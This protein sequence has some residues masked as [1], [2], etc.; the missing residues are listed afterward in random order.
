MNNQ[1]VFGALESIRGG[2]VASVQ[3]PDGSPLRSTA[4]ISALTAAILEGNPAGL[5]I[6][7]PEDIRAVRS[8]TRLPIIGLHKV[9]NGTRDI[10]TPELSL[11]VGLAQA[12]ADIIA[13]DAT[14]EVLG[15]DF[16]ILER[17]AS[18]TGLPVMADI[19]TFEEACRA[20]DLGVAV[21]STTLSG[22]TPESASVDS[23]P[24]LTLVSQL[25]ERGMTVIG[26]GRY[27]TLAQVESGFARGAFAIVVG[28]AISDPGSIT[29]EF[30]DVSPKRQRLLQ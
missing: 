14:W 7:G 13:V 15:G 23:G 16:S 27:R 6:N 30:V 18:E 17:V 3:A 9:H 19:S 28:G 1:A 22:Y 5:R 4:I 29:A 8:L 11:A 26:E 12:G 25:A 21:V 2:L 24:D 20:W 10:V